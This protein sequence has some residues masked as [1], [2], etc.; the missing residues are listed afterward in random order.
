M[1]TSALI[2]TIV[3]AFAMLL[4]TNLN[5]QKFS[6]LDK[7]PMDL[8][9]FPSK[10][11]KV[12][13][14]YYSRPQ[15]K[16]R[17]LSELT[18]N[19][20]VWRTGANEA[21]EITFFKD[22]NFGGKSIKAGTYVLATIPGEKEWTIIINSETDTWGAYSYDQAKDVARITA[23]VTMANES[24]EAFS[25]AFDDGGNMH[26]GWDKVRVAVPVK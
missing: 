13:K 26:L 21:T 5:A 10:G 19:G 18:P 1:K 7:S 23:P 3:I 11:D 15:L 4:T 22:V 6:G 24:L 2:S 8:A 16:D 12:V 20:K 9:S 25:I 17:S 14:I